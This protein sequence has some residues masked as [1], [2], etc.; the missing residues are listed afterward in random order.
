M[1][2]TLP[3]KGKKCGEVNAFV[4]QPKR[5]WDFCRKSFCAR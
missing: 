5:V 4:G 2:I 1:L 3:K